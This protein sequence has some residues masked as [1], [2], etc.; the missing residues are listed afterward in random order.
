MGSKGPEQSLKGGQSGLLQEPKSCLDQVML[1][2][3][4]ESPCTAAQRP[5]AF[6]GSTRVSLAGSS[7]P[8]L[9]RGL[10]SQLFNASFC[11]FSRCSFSG[12]FQP[13]AGHQPRLRSS[14]TQRAERRTEGG[15]G[16]GK[17]P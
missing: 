14:E 6:N 17:P 12:V 2:E 5:R 10:V 9:C 15:G 13:P 7:D 3:V 11:R 8:T 16:G 1:R 4:F